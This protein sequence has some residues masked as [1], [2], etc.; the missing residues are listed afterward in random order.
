MSMVSEYLFISKSGEIIIKPVLDSIRKII[1]PL[2][3]RHTELLI[4]RD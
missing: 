1:L 3:L 4:L 2:S